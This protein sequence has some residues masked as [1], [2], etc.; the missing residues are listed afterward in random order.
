MVFINYPETPPY[1]NYGVV[2]KDGKLVHY[3]PIELPGARWP[4]DFGMTERFAVFHDLPV[5]FDQE[6]LA[7]G[8]R[9]IKFHKELP[10]RFGVMPRV[11]T[12][13]DVKLF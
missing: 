10:S 13:D 4:H 7:R 3:V 11:G 8:R 12:R 6:D 5:F 2:D 9:S 1:M